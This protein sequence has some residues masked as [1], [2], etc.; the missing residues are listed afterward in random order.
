MKLDTNSSDSHIYDRHLDPLAIIPAVY[1]IAQNDSRSTTGVCVT[2][3]VTLDH[4]IFAFLWFQIR[5]PKQTTKE[6]YIVLYRNT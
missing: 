5:L 4:K 3:T 1:V 6:R 2:V